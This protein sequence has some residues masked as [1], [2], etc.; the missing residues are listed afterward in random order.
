MLRSPIS[1]TG[2][3]EVRRARVSRRSWR[4]FHPGD[5]GQVRVGHGQLPARGVH[6]APR[7]PPGAR[8][9]P[10]RATP[11]RR[12]VIGTVTARE[13]AGRPPRRDR[14]AREQRDAVGRRVGLLLARR[15]HPRGARR[16]RTAPRRSGARSPPSPP[17]P[18][19]SGRR[20]AERGWLRSTSCSAS[21]SASR[22]LDGVGEAV[23]VDP[24]VLGGPAVQDVEGGEPHP[25][26][27]ARPGCPRSTRDRWA[28]PRRRSGGVPA[29][30][31]SRR[32]RMRTRGHG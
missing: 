5:E 32:W 27:C 28:T 2:P 11:A 30:V 8:R 3:V 20:S 16:A 1:T 7:R 12:T 6:T 25:S 15:R 17:P 31:R 23:E 21:T 22:R 26:Q 4:A 10:A 9:A 29:A 14:V 19:R 24:V 18:P 13:A